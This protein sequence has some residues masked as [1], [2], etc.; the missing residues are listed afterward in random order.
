MTDLTELPADDVAWLDR[1]GFALSSL[2]ARLDLLANELWS[3]SREVQALAAV[4]DEASDVSP[5]V[6]TNP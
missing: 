1:Y 4:R 5:V 3:I 6:R 2:G